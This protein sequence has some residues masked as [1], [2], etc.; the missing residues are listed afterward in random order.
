VG[1]AGQH[2]ICLHGDTDLEKQH[3]ERVLLFYFYVSTMGH[4]FQESF[5]ETPYSLSKDCFEQQQEKIIWQQ[6]HDK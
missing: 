2:N 4:L 6:Y 3:F 5:Q 1:A